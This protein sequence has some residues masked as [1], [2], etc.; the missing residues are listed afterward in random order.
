MNLMEIHSQR[1]EVL[2]HK[3]LKTLLLLGMYVLILIKHS[4][5]VSVSIHI[6]YSTLTSTNS[7]QLFKGIASEAEVLLDDLQ[8][9][10]HNQETKLATYAQQQREV[11]FC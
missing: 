6:F 2:I 5:K 11:G 3:F 8:N 1:L 4:L 10:L 9:I 7:I